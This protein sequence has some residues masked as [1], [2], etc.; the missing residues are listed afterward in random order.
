MSRGPLQVDLPLLASVDPN[1]I[2]G[3]VV[4]HPFLTLENGV[5]AWSAIMTNLAISGVI[6][7]FLGLWIARH[8][9]TGPEAEG[10]GR[11]TT[12]N[13]F[14]H[15]IEVMCVYL[16]DEMVRPL[17]GERTDRFMPFLWTLFFFILINNL[18]G[19]VPLLD[20]V[21]L[22][23]KDLK[24]EHRSFVGGT[25]TQSI[26]VTGALALVSICVITYAG[27][28][29]LGV[30]GYL[31]H[32]TGGVPLKWYFLP[33]I[34]LVFVIEMISN[35]IVKPVALAIRLFANMTAGHILLATL[36]A[37]T[38]AFWS[39]GP[40]VGSLAFVIATAGSFAIFCLELFVALMQAF[41]F[42]FL[43][44]V[45]I[46]L[47]SHGDEHHEEHAHGEHGRG[48]H[49]HEEHHHGHAPVPA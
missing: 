25:A 5:W 19:L 22:M 10:A 27:I 45:F 43:T 18:L 8:V 36:L 47:L 39:Q 13:P 38:G 29:E 37:L 35:L 26:Y 3:H 7:V 20:L 14:A 30:V 12:K 44:T 6:M 17:L 23:F 16:R 32:A 34:L 1:K 15:A 11:Y 2:V 46:S 41:I 33:I 48:D 21:H 24:S 28:R 4:N 42:F 9:A 49:H 40:V 31:H